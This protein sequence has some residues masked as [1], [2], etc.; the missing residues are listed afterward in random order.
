[1]TVPSPDAREPAWPDVQLWFETIDAIIRGLGHALNNRALALSATIESLDPKRPVGQ[2]LATAL[3][4][5]SERLTEQLRQLRA[6]PF[7]IEREPM[8]LLL[9]DVLSAAM[10]LHRS[11]ASL[12]AVPVYLEGAMDAPPV[13]VPESALMHATLVTLTALKGFAAPGGAVRISA[14]GTADQAVISFLA[15]RDPAD[16]H[17]AARSQALI[18]PSSLAVALI[19]DGL[20]EIEQTLGPEAA[21]IHWTL[22]SLK[23]MRRKAREAAAIG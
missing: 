10:H 22:P 15:Q 2:Q 12:G 19:G 16:A 17:D 5:E 11:H 14:T 18:A 7:A 1:M 23:A 4:R 9:R 21:T 20:V 8:P 6:L 3:T 13:L